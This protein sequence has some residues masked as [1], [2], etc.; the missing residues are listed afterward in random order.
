MQAFS[1]YEIMSGQFINDDSGISLHA[2]KKEAPKNFQSQSFGL[3]LDSHES[4]KELP[5]RKKKKGSSKNADFGEVIN[6]TPFEGENSKPENH[7]DDLFDEIVY[8][9][10]DDSLFH[11]V[12]ADEEDL[13]FNDEDFYSSDE[14]YQPEFTNLKSR[15]R[16]RSRRKRFPAVKTRFDYNKLSSRRPN[17]RPS[18]QP[19]KFMNNG[20]RRSHPSSLLKPLSPKARP[21]S[22]HKFDNME[23]FRVPTSKKDKDMI[24]IKI[25][26]SKSSSNQG[27]DFGPRPALSRNTRRGPTSFPDRRIGGRRQHGGE[28]RVSYR[29]ACII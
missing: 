25:D 29:N 12:Y 7:P 21:Q 23:I 27:Q 1:S 10:N 3:N 13:G 24:A 9:F 20:G 14:S 16:D 4:F 8:D 6:L 2:K 28:R 11:D 18:V 26:G 22:L 15:Q 17:Q 5:K 19:S